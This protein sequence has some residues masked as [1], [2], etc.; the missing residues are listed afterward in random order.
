MK[1]STGLPPE[2]ETETHPTREE[3]CATHEGTFLG[4]I[5]VLWN[6]ADSS[7]MGKNAF[8][9]ALIITACALYNCVAWGAS[10]IFPEFEN[11][12]FP[13]RLNELPKEQKV[14]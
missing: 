7:I 9:D 1:Q 5:P 3:F 8:W 11:P 14:G 12:G 2:A 10:W 4:F 13:L 6:E